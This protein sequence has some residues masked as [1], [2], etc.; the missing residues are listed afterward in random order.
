MAL[1]QIAAKYTQFGA[2]LITK[3]LHLVG[4]FSPSKGSSV[5]VCQHPRY[6]AF[7]T[8]SP[9]LFCVDPAVTIVISQNAMET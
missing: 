8:L 9:K 5:C 3:Q 7:E 2:Q 6:D 4:R 1:L